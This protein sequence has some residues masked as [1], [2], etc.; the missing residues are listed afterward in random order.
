MPNQYH[1][2][3]HVLRIAILP[4]DVFSVITLTLG[5]GKLVILIVDTLSSF[6][7]NYVNF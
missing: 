2:A 4:Q 1:R 6:L 3:V 5:L 7:I